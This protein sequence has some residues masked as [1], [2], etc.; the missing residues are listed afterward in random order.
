MTTNL[1]NDLLDLGKLQ[2][3]AFEFHWERFNL[4]EVVE[5]A[6]TILSF[7]AKSSNIEL[8]LVIDPS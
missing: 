6:F 7:N 3:F 2:N 4:V 1:I 5:K 8:R